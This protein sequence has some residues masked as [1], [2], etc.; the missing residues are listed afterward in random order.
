MSGFDADWLAL[1]EPADHAARSE[2]L[3]RRLRPLLDRRPLIRAVDLASGSGSNVRWLRGRLPRPQH[4]TLVD[5]DGGLLALAARGAP[6]HRRV[7][8]DLAAELEALPLAGADLVTASAFLDLVS[9]PWLERLV[10]GLAGTPAVLLFALSVDGRIDWS[11]ALPQD[12][13][14]LAAYRRH[15]RRDKGFGP[16]LGPAVCTAAERLLARFGYQVLAE[17]SDWVL[18]PDEAALQGAIAENHAGAAAEARPDLAAAAED[19][20]ARRRA[21]IAAGESRLRIGH[22]DL[23]AWQPAGRSRTARPR[24]S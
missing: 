3:A 24:P 16:A 15:Q 7:L 23:L 4:W 17:R 11:P 19:W 14:L 22:R 2:A 20:L 9:E 1:R 8:C 5:N 13:A 10:A 6:R 21:L 12:R 18:G